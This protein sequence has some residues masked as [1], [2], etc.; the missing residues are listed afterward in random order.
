V[1]TPKPPTCS[2]PVRPSPTATRTVLWWWENRSSLIGHDPSRLPELA[3]L[4]ENSVYN[5]LISPQFG[6]QF[7]KHAMD[8]AEK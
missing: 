7:L 2:S 6:I 5:S 8:S 3:G 4:G 1:P